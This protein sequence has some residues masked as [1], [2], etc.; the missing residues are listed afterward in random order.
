MQRCKG[1]DSRQNRAEKTHTC[2]CVLSLLRS[3]S[4]PH[5]NTPKD[6]QLKGTDVGI[7][8]NKLKMA[9]KI[10]TISDHHLRATLSKSDFVA[11]FTA[12]ENEMFAREATVNCGAVGEKCV[13]VCRFCVCTRSVCV[14]MWRLCSTSAASA[15]VGRTGKHVQH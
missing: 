3:F 6:N 13:H 4:T 1:T 5:A 12:C 14:C 8:N 10:T 11:S 7:C 9:S 2:T 15:S